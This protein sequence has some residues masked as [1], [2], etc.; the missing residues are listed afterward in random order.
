MNRE[1]LR[2]R[3]V[4]W[5]EGQAIDELEELAMFESRPNHPIPRV[6]E[7]MLQVH[8]PSSETPTQALRVR[9]V[10]HDLRALPD[11]PAVLL[12]VEPT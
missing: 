10:A 8:G 1:R 7:L 2:L 5:Q 12:A 9:A 4:V 6:G 11:S 3:V